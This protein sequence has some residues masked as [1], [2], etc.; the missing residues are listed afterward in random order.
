M[1]ALA[2]EDEDMA[3]E[4]IGAD[5]LLCL[6]RRAD[7][8][9]GKRERPS[10]PAAGQSSEPPQGRQDP[11]QRLLVGGTIDPHPNPVRQIDLDYPDTLGQGQAG[12]PRAYCT[13]RDWHCRALTRRIGDDT[14]LNKFRRPHSGGSRR[15][16]CGLPRRSPIVQQACR[17]PVPASNHRNLPALGLY[18]G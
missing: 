13:R 3:A 6:R 10:F 5:D 2:A 12:T 17:N 14:E 18:L 1:A 11:P 16:R 9:A 4:R 15:H 7:R 8:L